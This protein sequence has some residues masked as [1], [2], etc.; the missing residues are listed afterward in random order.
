MKKNMI[1]RVSAMT[2]AG[3]MMFGGMQIP[4]LAATADMTGWYSFRKCWKCRMRRAQ[5]CQM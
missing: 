3:A 2:M 4:A 5:V 1:G